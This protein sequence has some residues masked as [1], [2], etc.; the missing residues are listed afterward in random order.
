MIILPGQLTTATYALLCY[1][2]R[3]QLGLQPERIIHARAEAQ[4]RLKL[5]KPLD[6][7]CWSGG[8]PDITC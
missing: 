8:Q 7:V 5:P 4:V 2:Q 1:S 3:T 6:A